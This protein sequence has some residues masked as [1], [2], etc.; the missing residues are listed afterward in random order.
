GGAGW[1]W[2]KLEGSARRS[3]AGG[4][5]EGEQALVGLPGPG[6][7]RAEARAE[8]FVAGGEERAGLVRAA[9]G[10]EGGAE[11]APGARDVGV[12]GWQR[13]LL[14]GEGVTEGRVGGPPP[15]HQ[16]VA[17]RGEGAAHGEVLRAEPL[18]EER[19][20]AAGGGLGL[21]QLPELAERL[22]EVDEGEP[23]VRV[24]LAQRLLVDG[25]GLAEDR[26]GLGVAAEGAEGGAEV[27]ERERDVV[28]PLPERAAEALD[29]L[30]LERGGLLPPPLV[31][32]DGA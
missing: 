30:G 17:E 31:V 15:V 8:G 21:L 11:G 20:R 7:V 27:A 3:A 12:V 16:D 19:D 6:V 25:G 1:A 32:A 9:E 29:G 28:V 23:H 22:G 2:G 13:R 14:H 18:A 10:G 5:L 4:L 26:L 24:R